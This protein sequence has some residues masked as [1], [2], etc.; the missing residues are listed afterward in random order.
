MRVVLR[1]IWVWTAVIIIVLAWLPLLAVIRL[2]DRDPAH[3]HTGRWLRRAGKLA[4]LANPAWHIE[5]QGERVKDPRRPYV[6]VCN[7]QS[8][9]DIPVAC[10]LSMEMKWVAKIELFRMPLFGWLLRLAGDIP[11]DRKDKNSRRRV[12]AHT[13]FYLRKKCSVMFFPE[14]TRSRDGRVLRF[15]SGAFRTAIRAQVP[16]LPLAVDGAQNALPKHDWR[17]RESVHIRLKVLPPVETEGMTVDDVP[18]LREE[19]R[20]RIIEQLAEWRGVAP[21][22]VDAMATQ[23]ELKEAARTSESEHV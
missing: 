16:V 2:L 7:H 10:N 18:E 17:L 3:Y 13:R 6:V 1:S 8:M 22:Q 4:T 21:A 15:T 11:V 5:V 12:L 20:R 14:G 9:A 19:V 23:A